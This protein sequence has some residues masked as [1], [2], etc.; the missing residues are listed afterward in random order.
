MECQINTYKIVNIISSLLLIKAYVFIMVQSFENII[1]SKNNN[2]SIIAEI[3]Y[4]SNFP[5][6]Y[7]Q[8]YKVK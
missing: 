7:I 1:F 5:M 6:K 4:M 2:N 8:I 3:L